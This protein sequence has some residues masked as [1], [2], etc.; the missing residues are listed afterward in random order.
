[1]ENSAN[2]HGYKDLGNKLALLKHGYIFKK[3]ILPDLED[4]E[5]KYTDFNVENLPNSD[6]LSVYFDKNRDSKQQSKMRN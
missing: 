1:M 4:P 5:A 2:D 6:K 3:G